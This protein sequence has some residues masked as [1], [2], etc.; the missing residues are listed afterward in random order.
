MTTGTQQ[1]APPSLITVLNQLGDLIEEG[2]A[3]TEARFASIDARFNSVDARF[4]S[5][6]ARFTSID[7]RL[8]TIDA[9]FDRLE[10]G[11]TETQEQLARM[12]LA[13]ER[14]EKHIDGRFE[15]LAGLIRRDEFKEH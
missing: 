1:P 6:D 4:N 15:Q 13:N 10:T 7:A 9:R 3:R 11:L 2:Q 5:I 14:R 12:E 8:T